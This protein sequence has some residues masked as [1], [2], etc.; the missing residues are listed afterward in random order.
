MSNFL[1]KGKRQLIVKQK[2]KEKQVMKDYLSSV[3]AMQ[4]LHGVFRA[5]GIVLT[6]ENIHAEV[7]KRTNKKLSDRMIALLLDEFKE[8]KDDKPIETPV[9]GSNSDIDKL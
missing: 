5:E 3:K 7:A 6:E 1:R 9:T 4:F 2:K 8:K